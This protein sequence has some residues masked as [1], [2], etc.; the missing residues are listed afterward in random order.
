MTRAEDVEGAVEL[1]GQLLDEA[2]RQRNLRERSRAERLN[3]ILAHPRGFDV[4][5]A[6]T[7]EVLRVRQPVRAARLLSDLVRDAGDAIDAFGRIDRTTLR[8]GGRL[9]RP[10]PWLVVPAV[11]RRVRSEI[12]EVILPAGTRE[13]SAHAR[14]RRSL[15]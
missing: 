1:A 6:L 9:A 5:L 14:R 15:R 4:L 7:D 8:A 3:R 10:L 12:G 2:D 13:L 11:R